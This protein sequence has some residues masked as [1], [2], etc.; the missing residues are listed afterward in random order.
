MLQKWL[1]NLKCIQKGNVKGYG[2][3]ELHGWLFNLLARNNIELSTRLHN[4]VEKPF[5]IGPFQGG[6]KEKGKT[7]FREDNSYNFSIAGLN[8]EITESL[9]QVFSKI[10][11]DKVQLRDA[12]FKIEEINTEFINP[13]SY[14]DL[15]E[16]SFTGSNSI[17]LEFCSPT[18]FRQQGTQ[19]VFPQP[20]L[21]WGGLLRKWN[22]FSPVL[23]ADDLMYANILVKKYNLR[24]ELVD[25]GQFKIIGCIGSC[26]Y[27]LDKRMPDFQK[28]ILKTLAYYAEI[29]G[30]GYKT[31]MSLGQVK[32]ING[33][34]R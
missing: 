27:E 33:E 22:K 11:G 6:E 18:S 19:E 3:S 1:I 4:S 29:A 12:V 20:K 26:T 24:T 8:P 23:F 9:N 28:K 21:V 30:I 7:L 25:F 10:K 13:L 31:S 16:R 2:G 15:L 5:T 17:T 34:G 14:F 32:Y